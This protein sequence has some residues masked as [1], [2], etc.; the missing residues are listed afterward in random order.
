MAFGTDTP[1]DS[2]LRPQIS[3]YS[4]ESA[5][6]FMSA[7]HLLADG[8]GLAHGAATEVQVSIFY[9]QSIPDAQP[10][11]LKPKIRKIQGPTRTI[12]GSG[13]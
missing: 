12:T 10:L 9:C 13:Y 4:G 2:V 1:L 8:S 7:P 5:A 11:S 3:P 6:S